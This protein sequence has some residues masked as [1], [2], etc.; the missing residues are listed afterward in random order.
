STISCGPGHF[1]L[2]ATSGT[3]EVSTTWS[4]RRE[5]RFDGLCAET[6][7]LLTLVPNTQFTS[8]GL[9]TDVVS[10]F[11]DHTMAVVL[12][13]Q[14]AGPAES[15]GKISSSTCQLAYRRSESLFHIPGALDELQVITHFMNDHTVPSSLTVYGDWAFQLENST[16]AT[17]WYSVQVL[18]FQG[19]PSFRLRS[20]Y[21]PLGRDKK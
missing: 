18:E 13:L 20:Q 8:E 11:A 5:Q 10:L 2:R 16:E 14:F 4:T 12:S 3:A 19:R 7:P 6:E 9:C 1:I 15:Y 21:E 17:P